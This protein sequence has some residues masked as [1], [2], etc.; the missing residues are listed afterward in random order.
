MSELVSSR[1]LERL[2]RLD[3]VARRAGAGG[4]VG[5]RSAGRAGLGTIFHEHRTYT[6]GDDPRYVD[7]NAYRR[8]RSLHVKVYEHE[9]N[10]D[11][12]LLVDRSASMGSGDR[13]K[14][15]T[16]CSMAAMVGAVALARGDTVRV[17]ALPAR[18]GGMVETTVLRG[19]PSTRA[20][21]ELLSGLETGVNAPLGTALREALPKMRRRGFVLL[22]T[23]FLEAGGE[24]EAGWRRAVDYLRFMRVELT[25]LHMVSPFERDPGLAGPVRLR[26]VETNALLHVDVNDRRLELYRENFERWLRSIA[27]Y[28]RQKDTRHMVVDAGKDDET[29]LLHRLMTGGVLR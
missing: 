19:R 20:L 16:G 27:A 5:E 22:V 7:W 24:V 23:D 29:A 10:L 11:V 2:G 25:C 9:E 28:L 12:H 26:D 1:L 3:L 4:G 21:V 13:S 6:P 8:M 18:L 15:E 14:L 17:T